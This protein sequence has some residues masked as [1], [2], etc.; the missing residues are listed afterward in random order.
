MAAML[1][2]GTDWLSRFAPRKSRELCVYAQYRLKPIVLSRLASYASA[3]ALLES[4]CWRFQCH[5]ECSRRIV[6]GVGKK[7]RV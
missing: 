6:F 7:R 2:D 3:A 5:Q 1:V 4:S